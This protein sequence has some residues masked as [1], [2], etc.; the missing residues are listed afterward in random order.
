MSESPIFEAARQG[1]AAAVRACLAAGADPA[2]PNRHGFTALQTAAMGANTAPLERNLAVLRL[3]LD[4]GSPLEYRGHDGR[5]AL[6]LAA[7]FAPT[8]D[9]VQLLLDAGANA[10]ICDRHGNHVTVNAM[11]EDV[12]ELLSRASGK[13]IPEPPP[14]EPEPVKMTPA[15]WRAARLRI[16]AV[17][18][19]LGRAGVVALHDAGYTQADGFADASEAFHDGGGEAAGLHGICFYTRQ[20]LNAAKRSSRLS[21]AFWGAPQG[22]DADMLRVGRLVVGAF[23]AAGFALQWNE[24]AAQR[25]ALDLRDGEPGPEPPG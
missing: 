18:Q 3:L 13:P 23:R 14:P 21:L 16:E 7:E 22:A 8:T 2:A 9:A 4:A 20:D 1:D 6:Y 25:P 10:D 12:A 5:T 15:Q 11:M 24:M 17:F 19:A